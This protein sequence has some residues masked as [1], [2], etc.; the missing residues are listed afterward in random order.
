[1]CLPSRSLVPLSL[2]RLVCKR[3]ASPFKESSTSLDSSNLTY[4]NLCQLYMEDSTHDI[5]I[6]S[7]KT[8]PRLQQNVVEGM[9]VFFGSFL[10]FFCF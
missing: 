9:W 3:V 8:K 5:E 10:M 2:I 1:M 7:S 6:I 4:H